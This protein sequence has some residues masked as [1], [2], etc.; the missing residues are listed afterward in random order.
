MRW[1]LVLLIL[2]T[3][4]SLLE[5][6]PY[7]PDNPKPSP[8]VV[9]G[10]VDAV[11]APPPGASRI[12]VSELRSFL[13]DIGL[14]LEAFTELVSNIGPCSGSLAVIDINDVPLGAAI[15]L[16]EGL[17]EAGIAIPL[18]LDGRSSY[19]GGQTDYL[20]AINAEAAF[21]GGFG[22]EGVTVAVLD[23]GVSETAE[24]S[25]RLL[26]GYNAIDENS[27]TQDD[28]L[29]GTPVAVLAAGSESGVAREASVLPVK[30]C[31]GG[32]CYSSDIIRGMCWAVDN[33]PDGP[34]ALVMNLSLGGEA[35]S[36]II[37]SIL[38]AAIDS[39]VVVAAAGGNDEERGASSHYPAAHNFSG[40]MAVASV[41]QDEAGGWVPTDFSTR[42]NYIDIAAPGVGFDL[43]GVASDLSGTS[44]STPLVSGTMAVLRGANPNLSPA[45]IQGCIEAGAQDLSD[46]SDAV[47][48]G[49]LDVAG[50]LEACGL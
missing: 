49:L 14:R 15:R 22:G 41:E 4:C 11:L 6:L 24:L 25:G 9:T 20:S 28:D 36:E 10:Q 33:A 27:D 21:E 46:S 30:V 5:D 3:G 23:S 18:G 8:G 37:E 35:P 26:P 7:G 19:S 31:E 42:G 40:L 13:D 45:M 29:H 32:V 12:D 47:G 48:E 34:D 38:D 39:G 44:Y 1:I 2:L 43:P 17:E 50:A 16:L